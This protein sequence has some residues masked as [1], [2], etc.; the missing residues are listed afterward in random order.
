[1][2]TTV[3]D[4]LIGEKLTPF[5]LAPGSVEDEIS[6]PL[7]KELSRLKGLVSQAESMSIRVES[8]RQAHLTGSSTP[9]ESLHELE[10]WLERSSAPLDVEGDAGPLEGLQKMRSRQ[11]V[12]LEARRK[13]LESALDDSKRE[14]ARLSEGQPEGF[15]APDGSEIARMR[16]QVALAEQ[17]VKR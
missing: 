13:G 8:V 4:N 3:S 2:L 16:D 6:N 17:L 1:M 11:Q 15:E 14:L 9:A 7:A 10:S 5:S 12:E